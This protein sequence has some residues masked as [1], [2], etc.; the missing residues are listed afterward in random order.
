MKIPTYKEYTWRT[1]GLNG[2]TVAANVMLA[3][4]VFSAIS[5]AW[6]FLSIPLA[7]LGIGLELNPVA[8]HIK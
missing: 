8:H 5:P 3:A 4:I 6:L 7:V 1:L 2:Y